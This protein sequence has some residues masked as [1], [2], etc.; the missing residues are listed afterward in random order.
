MR[1]R[2]GQFALRA[3]DVFQ[4]FPLLVLAIVV[5]TLTG[6]RVENVVFAIAMIN[7]PRLVRLVH[8]EVLPL[9]ETR[10]IEAALAM[11]ASPLRIMFRHILPNVTSIILV[12]ASLCAANAIVVV[13][14]LSFFGVGVTPPEATWGAMLQTGAPYVTVGKWW[15]VVFPGLAVFL[16]VI[17]LNIIADGLSFATDAANRS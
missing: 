12:Q 4:A 2:W 15:V 6:N 8:S 3:L 5:V 14:T 7:A 16:A 11:G 13:A 1:G 9:R 17:C 10:F